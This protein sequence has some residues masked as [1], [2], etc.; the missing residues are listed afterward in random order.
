[1]A[2]LLDLYKN[3]K[4]CTNPGCAG[5]SIL[6]K[7]KPIHAYMDY[8]E[9]VQSDVLFLLD[10]VR[11][12]G[13]HVGS[14]TDNETAVFKSYVKPIVKNFTVLRRMICLPLTWRPVAS[15]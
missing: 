5:C 7:P 15:T 12:D 13:Y 2:D 14:M 3:R 10:S 6:E 11:W 4:N 9:L 1:M 8:E